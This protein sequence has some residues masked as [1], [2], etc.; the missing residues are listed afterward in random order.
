MPRTATV[1]IACARCGGIRWVPAPAGEPFLCARCRTALAGGP[2]IDPLAAAEARARRPARRL[3]DPGAGAST[4]GQELSGRAGEY[5][6]SPPPGGQ[7]SFDL[8]AAP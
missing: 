5:Q 2:A 6:D 4:A 1:E 7:A 3:A 8:G